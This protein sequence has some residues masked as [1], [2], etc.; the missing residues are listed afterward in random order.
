[1]SR[2]SRRNAVA[3]FLAQAVVLGVIDALVVSAFDVA[4]SLFI[5]LILSLVPALFAKYVLALGQSSRLGWLWVV[6]FGGV[7]FLT[8][9][10]VPK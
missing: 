2:L 1:M 9:H 7:F 10:F 6:L 5:V 8:S 3:S 4:L